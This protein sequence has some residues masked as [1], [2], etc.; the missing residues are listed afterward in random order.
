MVATQVTKIPMSRRSKIAK[1]PRDTRSLRGESQEVVEEAAPT[2]A[3][4]TTVEVAANTITLSP[5]R[6]VTVLTVIRIISI[7]TRE[8]TE[9]REETGIGTSR[10]TPDITTSPATD[11]D[12]RHTRRVRAGAGGAWV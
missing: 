9:T 12:D 7:Q 10:E 3:P 1:N 4:V 8:I 11:R 6:A 5:V 2:R